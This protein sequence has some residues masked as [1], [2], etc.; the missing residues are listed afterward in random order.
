MR[1]YL[2]PEAERDSSSVKNKLEQVE[3]TARAAGFPLLEAA[4]LRTRIMLLAEWEK[5]V[6]PAVSLAE[7]S[8][9]RL[10]GD[11][12]HFLIMEVT[13]RQLS[14]AGKSHEAMTWLT[15]AIVCDAYHNSLWRRNVL[16]TMAK[17]HGP[18]DPR[19]ATEFTAEAVRVCENGKLQDS[20]Y[21][22]ALAEHGMALWRAGESTRSFRM[23]DDATDR[24][25][26]IRSDTDAWKAQFA[27][28]FAVIAYFSG[29]GK[30]GKPQEGHVEPEQ[31]LFLSSDGEAHTAYRPEHLSYICIRLAMFADALRDIPKAAAWTWKAIELAKENPSARITVSQQSW[32]AMPAAL[33]ADD[34]VKAARLA[35]IMTQTDIDTIA[36]ALRASVGVVSTKTAAAFEDMVGSAALKSGLR[37]I[38]IIPIVVRLALLQFR[39][40]ASPAI[41]SYLMEIESIIPTQ[42]QPENFIAEAKRSLIDETGWTVLRDDGFR[43]IQTNE[44][45]RGFV[46]CIGAMGKAP[47]A[48][49]LYLQTYLA[50]QFEQLFQ[51]RPSIYREIIAPLFL[52]YW[53]R[54]IALS[55]TLFRTSPAY[56]R[57]QLRC[58]DGSA[59]G[60]RKL[61]SAMR[62]CLGVTFPE[63][64][65]DW[66]DS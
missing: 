19:K 63:E 21:I 41:A 53:E 54:A 4:A 38:S 66:L 45:I 44:Y 29:I 58:V 15:R 51:T 3:A 39:G 18:T 25:F 1:E 40:M 11:E 20:L 7:S 26:T 13:G 33:V 9:N 27:R 61:L 6:E 2:K 17:L 31:G 10:D 37:L 22:E 50:Q 64:T 59:A 32:Y 46:L 24:I 16:I 14:Y 43:A 5:Q 34:F 55:A 56:T 57:Q 62:F 28:L 49:S 30:N 48:Q 23:F 47:T 36:L 8:L 60:T 65:Q 12:C 52:A 42:L 35:A